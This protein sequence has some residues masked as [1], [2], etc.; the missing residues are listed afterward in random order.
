MARILLIEDD[1]Y[2]GEAIR[3]MLQTLGHEVEWVQNGKQAKTCL[4]G[5]ALFQLVLTDILMPEMDGFESIQFL[6]QEHPGLPIIAMSGQRDTPY[7]RTAAH[8]GAKLTLAK[9]FA[10]EDLKASLDQVL[11]G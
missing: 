2:N 7:L 1:P 6:K 3:L 11:A 9:P 8:F 4:R 5:G 10:L